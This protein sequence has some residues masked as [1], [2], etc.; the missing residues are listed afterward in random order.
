MKVGKLV[1]FQAKISFTNFTNFGTTQYSLTVPFAPAHDVH[2]RWGEFWDASASTSYPISLRIAA[3]ST[4]GTLWCIST[5][6]A[7]GSDAALDKN[8]LVTVATAD[9]LII[10]G[11]YEA[12]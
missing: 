1:N 7:K 9:H 3:G 8:S 6:S 10:S 12:Q 11:S 5:N 2:F 4:T